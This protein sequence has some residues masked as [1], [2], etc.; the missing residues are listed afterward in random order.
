MDSS[1]KTV[2][3]TGAAGF[4]GLNIVK[5]YVKAGW[6][7]YALVHKTMPEELRTLSN[8]EIIQGDASDK[9]TLPDLKVDVVVHA[10]GLASDIGRDE[11]F[12]KINFEPV[13]FLSKLAE[14]KFIYISSTDVYGIKDFEDADENTPLLEFPKNP[15]PKYK[16]ASEGWIKEN[17]KQY[18]IIRP[19]AVWGEGDRTLEKRVVE[20]LQT[21]PFIVHFGKWRGQ[22]PWPLANVKNVAD[23]IVRVSETD[24]FDN[25]AVNIIDPEITTIDGYYRMIAEKYYPQKTFREIYLPLWIGKLI[26]LVSTFVSNILKRKR[27]VFDPTFY[28]VHHVSSTLDFSSKKMNEILR[29]K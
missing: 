22:N 7:V 12:R 17:C 28:A 6:Y 15:Y 13:K 14:K 2:F 1:R 10:A 24:D 23:V 19:A 4:I 29:H 20:F 25:Q 21:S 16:I 8:V 11:E 26:G 5:A 18:V 27:P 9:Q 3:V